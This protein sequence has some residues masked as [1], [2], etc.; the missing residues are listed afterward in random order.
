MGRV[1]KGY[2]MIPLGKDLDDI[3]SIRRFAFVTS[4]VCLT[5]DL[6]TS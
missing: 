6:R 2:Q 4:L 5:L 3:L 1:M